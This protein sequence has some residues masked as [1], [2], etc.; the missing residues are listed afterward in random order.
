MYHN[1]LFAK[2]TCAHVLVSWHFIGYL[3]I[4]VFIWLHQVLVEACG[5]SFLD[6]GLNLGPLC[7]E[8]RVL[9]AGPPRIMLGFI[10]HFIF[11][12]SGRSMHNG[13]IGQ[14]SIIWPS[15]IYLYNPWLLVT[16]IV[17]I[18]TF[19]NKAVLSSPEVL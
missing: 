5:I 15:I 10:Y 18:S 13:C 16:H 6:Q 8:C 9:A 11:F 12:H 17:S 3:F 7:W 19:K 1:L 2:H 4:Y 14:D